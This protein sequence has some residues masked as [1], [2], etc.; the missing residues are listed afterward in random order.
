MWENEL[1][2]NNDNIYNWNL[3]KKRGINEIILD[4]NGF[5]LIYDEIFFKYN[6]RVISSFQGYYEVY[7]VVFF[8]GDEVI[9]W[10]FLVVGGVIIQD[11]YC[12]LGYK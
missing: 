6:V 7:S 2:R 11:E 5:L 1:I 8:G 9:V 12:Y 10:F 4:E 3:W